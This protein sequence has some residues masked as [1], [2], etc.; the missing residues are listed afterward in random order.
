[1]TILFVEDDA[2]ILQFVRRGLMAEGYVI[3]VATDGA[4][5][6]QLAM[7]P[8]YELILLDVML[9]GVNG[10]EICRQLRL[11]GVTTPIF[12]LT[13][14]DTLDDKVGG[15]RI[16]ADDY[17][18]KPF[19]FDELIVRIEALLRR[20]KGYKEEETVLKVDD[21]SLNREAREVRRGKRRIE[22]TAKEY[23]LL[24]YLMCAQGKVISRTKI[25]DN[26]WGHNNDPLTNVVDVYIRNLRRKIDDGELKPLIKTVRGFG[27]KLDA[28]EGN[29]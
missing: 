4:Q 12:M 5:G 11:R 10:L 14:M 18:T 1:M 28:Q 17:L 23:A 3:D 16:G 21:L 6:L 9:P 2:R 13:A 26:V 22:L 7:S 25:L 8:V 27:Y 20:S 29:W 24:E 15:L 19:A